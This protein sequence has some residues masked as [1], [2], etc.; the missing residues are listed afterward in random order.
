M[1]VDIL[2]IVFTPEML[3]FALFGTFLGILFAAIPGLNCAVGVSLLLPV[4]F[5]LSPAAGL[6]MLGGIYMGGMY[7]GSITSIL[8]N[9]PGCVEA[10]CTAWEGYPLTE[11]GRSREALYYS[12]FASTLGGLLGILCLI[13]LTPPLAKFALK[14]GSPEMFLLGLAG[15]TVVGTLAGEN[16]WKSLF[17]CALG[18]FISTIGMDSMTTV[19]RMT[20]GISALNTGIKSVSIVI[21]FYCFSEMFKNIGQKKSETFKF[22]DNPIKATTVIADIFKHWFL[23][24]KSILLGILLGIL[25]GIG[26]GTASFVAYGEAKRSAKHPETFGKGNPDGIIAAESANNA[27]VG[28]ALIPLLTLGIPGSTTAAIIGAALTMH[29]LI[30]GPELFSMRPDVAYIFMYGMML[31]VI[32]MG[33]IGAFGIKW[34]NKIL[35]INMFYLIPIVIVFALFGAFSLSNNMTDVYTAVVFGIIGALLKAFDVPLSPVM[36]GVVL[37]QLIE[38]NLR[39]TMKMSKAAGVNIVQYCAGRPGC[40]IL[41]VILI[42]FIILFTNSRR[43]QKKAAASN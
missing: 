26:G 16:I 36:I 6:L 43:K 23:L 9:V 28:G 2:K 15:L 32:A 18:L 35:K 25:P 33:L 31:S 13:F 19:K 12:I 40:I 30:M 11:Q 10:T 4:T 41:F 38:R 37:S 22:K 20:F 7:G 42:A 21:G 17:A 29:G 39:R 5:S 24:I 8:I 14:F 3:L 34:F 1:N 27:V